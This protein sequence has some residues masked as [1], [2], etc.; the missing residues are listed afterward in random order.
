M[1]KSRVRIAY[2]LGDVILLVTLFLEFQ[3]R[4]EIARGHI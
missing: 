2:T 4:A 3:Q 1:M